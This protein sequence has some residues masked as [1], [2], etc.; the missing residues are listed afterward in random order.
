MEW[1]APALSLQ[2]GAEVPVVATPAPDA[3]VSLS[4]MLPDHV[5][6]MLR[7]LLLWWSY[8]PGTAAIL[9]MLL[10]TW[11]SWWLENVSIAETHSRDRA[12]SLLRQ[13]QDCQAR[14]FVVP[15]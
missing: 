8:S 14:E 2:L 7:K 1:L 4:P 9:K 11:S 13:S 5:Q 10:F 3:S 15:L 12:I 6:L